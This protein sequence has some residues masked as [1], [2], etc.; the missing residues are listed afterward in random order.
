MCPSWRLATEICEPGFEMSIKFK[1]LMFVL[2][3]NW[4]NQENVKCDLQSSYIRCAGL[5]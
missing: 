4:T 1:E 5:H 2:F 3:F